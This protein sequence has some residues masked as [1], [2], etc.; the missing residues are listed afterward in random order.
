MFSGRDGGSRY[1]SRTGWAL[2][3]TMLDLG[4]SVGRDRVVPEDDDEDP[5]E[6]EEPRVR[7]E[8]LDDV[9]VEVGWDWVVGRRVTV[10]W[11][12]VL[13]VVWGCWYLL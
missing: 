5:D 12:G 10:C 7:D 9:R 6:D 11:T 8:P 2:A 3:L 13:Y 4:L 1:T